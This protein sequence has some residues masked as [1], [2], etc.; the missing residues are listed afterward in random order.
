MSKSNVCRPPLLCKQAKHTR[1]KW[2]SGKVCST[3]FAL[4]SATFTF[5]AGSA[6]T[7]PAAAPQLSYMRTPSDQRQLIFLNNPEFLWFTREACD[8][9]DKLPE[10]RRV[11]CE[12]SLFKIDHLGVGH[13]RAWWE[14]R[15]MMPFP[16]HSGIMITNT[17]HAPAKL[18]LTNDAIEPDSQ[19]RGGTEFVSLFTAPKKN[20]GFE[21]TPGERRFLGFTQL[22]K[23]RS[24]DFFAGVADFSVLSGE[25]TLEEVVFK[26]QPA[27]KLSHLG[28]T[29]RNLFTIQEGLVYKGVAEFSSITL[30]GA[31]FEISDSTAAGPLPVE[32]PLHEVLPFDQQDSTC[33]T[34]RTPACLNPALRKS[35]SPTRMNAWVTHIA[36]DPLDA[37]PKRKQAIISDLAELT[38]P[39]STPGCDS[40]WPQFS[41]SCIK[42][43]HNFFWYLQPL[44]LWRLPNWGNWGIHYRHPVSIVNQ[45]QHERVVC[46]R[47]RADGAST[48]AFRGSGIGTGWQQVFL[49]PRGGSRVSES[50]CIARGV[51][52]PFGRLNL[53][54]EFV[55]SGPAAG[56]LQHSVELE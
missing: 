23:I 54:A 43:S 50:Q 47:L 35:P 29:Q 40:R 38:L 3:A 16:I 46:L 2:L 48:I 14:H 42:M 30:Q 13:Y 32:Y 25:V 39:G 9:A 21:I 55:L 27:E 34:D 33:R 15:N 5:Q 56:T 20:I 11:N 53:E 17:S 26:D 12:K 7:T 44:K 36:P 28:Y 6:T 37:N 31:H 18:L 22:N 52:K 49:D 24:G 1:F 10:W 8:L 19:K 41:P 51:I 45:G 4:I